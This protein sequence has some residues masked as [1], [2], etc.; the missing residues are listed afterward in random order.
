MFLS[1]MSSAW[2]LGVGA[3]SPATSLG[4]PLLR[5]YFWSVGVQVFSFVLF[6]APLQARRSAPC[7]GGDPHPSLLA[8]CMYVTD[9]MASR[10]TAVGRLHGPRARAR[11][12][13]LGCHAQLAACG[14]VRS[15]RRR[16]T[17]DRPLCS[18]TVT[19]VRA[20]QVDSPMSPCHRAHT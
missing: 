8:S 17:R 3:E 6:L 16:I 19:E 20:H 12:G 5:G 4:I 13:P 15:C 10:T 14:P 11:A 1:A 9:R 7:V 18:V 2:P